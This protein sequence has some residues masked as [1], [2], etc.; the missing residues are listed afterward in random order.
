MVVDKKKQK[1]GK[2][3]GILKTQLGFRLDQ[4][5]GKYPIIDLQSR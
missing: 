1:N 2:N 5:H 3:I 4:K